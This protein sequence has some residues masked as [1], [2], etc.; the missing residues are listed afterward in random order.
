[1]AAG[2]K[3]RRKVTDT[4]SRGD[5]VLGRGYEPEHV[6]DLLNI[7][8]LSPRKLL[9]ESIQCKL[10]LLLF[11]LRKMVD[12][13]DTVLAQVELKL[14]TKTLKD[15]KYMTGVSINGPSSNRRTWIAILSSRMMG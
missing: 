1:M 12:K 4:A 14:S 7:M 6:L 3:I 10:F 5:E 8:K 13:M 2:S 15:L 11:S 9:F